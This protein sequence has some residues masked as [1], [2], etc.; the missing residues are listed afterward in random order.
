MKTCL[1]AAFLLAAS[2]LHAAGPAPVEDSVTISLGDYDLS[3]P[4]G[5]AALDGR[6]IAA[7]R[8]VCRAVRFVGPM[9]WIS[10]ARCNRETL[11]W[12]RQSAARAIAAAERREQLTRTAASR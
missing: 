5:R 4:E 8:S 9:D 7:S 12:A 3:S 2:P 6:L 1:P 10:R 11:A